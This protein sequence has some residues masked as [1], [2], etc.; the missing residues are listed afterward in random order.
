MRNIWKVLKVAALTCAGLAVA[1]VAFI[2]WLIPTGSE[3]CGDRSWAWTV[4]QEEVRAAL[5]APTS[6]EF[7]SITSA[8][9]E[10]S[11]DCEFTIRAHVD[12]ENSF[13]A[14]LRQP[15]SVKVEYIEEVDRYNAFDLAL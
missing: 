1:F 2:L 12:A 7:P 9:I 15:F 4:A 14:K 13:G 11:G 8:N 10:R 6:A 3:G 5:K